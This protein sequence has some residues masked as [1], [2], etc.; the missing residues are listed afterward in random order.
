MSDFKANVHQIRFSL[1]LRPDPA[2]EA[3]IC[4]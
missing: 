1:E 3:T 4:I 2:G